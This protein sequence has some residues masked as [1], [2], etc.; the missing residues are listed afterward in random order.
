MGGTRT[1]QLHHVGSRPRLVA[2]VLHLP[3]GQLG[4]RA[5][6]PRLQPSPALQQG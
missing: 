2:A 3:G 6:Q 4:G 1:L 5:G